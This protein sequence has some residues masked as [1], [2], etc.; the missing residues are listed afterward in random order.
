MTADI[1]SLASGLD[2]DVIRIGIGR[3]ELRKTWG[4]PHNYFRCTPIIVELVV[5][6]INKSTPIL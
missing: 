4:N 1:G 2:G 6:I 3:K 5:E